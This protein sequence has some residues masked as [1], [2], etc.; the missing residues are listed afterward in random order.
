MKK[1][2]KKPKLVGLC[3]AAPHDT[4]LTVCKQL[5]TA[6]N[7]VGDRGLCHENLGFGCGCCENCDLS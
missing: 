5:T 3:R 6:G 2:W 7:E 1:V 4:V